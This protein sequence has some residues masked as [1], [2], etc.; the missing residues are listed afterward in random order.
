VATSSS[1]DG[2]QTWTPRAQ[3]TG[4]FGPSSAVSSNGTLVVVGLVS[5]QPSLYK[6]NSSTDG[7]AT[8][9]TAV[10]AQH[11]GTHVSTGMRVTPAAVIEA[12]GAGNLY[13]TWNDCRY[14]TSCSA[15]DLVLTTSP[16]GVTWSAVSRIPI[17]ST[18][19]GVDHFIPGLGIDRST[20]GNSAHIVIP[21]YYFRDA[22]CALDK[23]RLYVGLI[24]SADGGASWDPPIKLYKHWMRV[25]WLADT[26]LGHMVGDYLS[27]AF[28][29][30]KAVTVFA[31]A[32]RPSHSGVFDEYMVEA[33]T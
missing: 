27:S 2:G 23:C 5:G 25:S 8:F 14:R 3:S 6:A 28:A 16:D 26:G 29:G 18:N 17:D 12:D 15:N 21:Y 33:A 22:A 11:G 4:L 31:V 1:D 32:K 19:S 7:G 13:V 20:G 10:I 30:G 9:T 24:S